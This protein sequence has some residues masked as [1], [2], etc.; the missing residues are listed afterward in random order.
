MNNSWRNAEERGRFQMD[1]TEAGISPKKTYYV[2]VGAKTV[3]ADKEAA[4]FEFAIHADEDEVRQLQ[5]LFEELQDADED[6]ALHFEG[7]P[8]VSNDSEDGMYNSLFADVY[9][10]LYKLGTQETKKHIESMG[11][12]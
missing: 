11:I 8:F 7:N 5:E 9:R 10:M 6:K 1:Q 3:L 12:L 2:A 4:S